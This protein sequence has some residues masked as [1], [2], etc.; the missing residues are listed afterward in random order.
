VHYKATSVEQ[1]FDPSDP[2]RSPHHQAANPHHEGETAR[3]QCRRVRPWFFVP[4]P[5]LSA[6]ENFDLKA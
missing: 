3:P 5:D 4:A 6:A 1:K 2:K